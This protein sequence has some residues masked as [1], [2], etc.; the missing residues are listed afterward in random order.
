M[1]LNVWNEEVDEDYV[2]FKLNKFNN[3]FYKFRVEI[4][5]TDKTIKAY[6]SASSGR[7]R[8]DLEIFEPRSEKPKGGIKALMWLKKELYELPKFLKDQFKVENFRV[9]ICVGWINSQRR[10]V[11]SRLEKEGYLMTKDKFGFILM[12][13]IIYN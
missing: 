11:Y 5:F 2:Y 6:I 4:E 10:R 12:K 3:T 1:E 9:Y 7:K 13:E 8:K